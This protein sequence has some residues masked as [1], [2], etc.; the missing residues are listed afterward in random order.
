VHG[1]ESGKDL[2]VES[3]TV[4]AAVWPGVSEWEEHGSRTH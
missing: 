3:L 2:Y 4:G 1:R